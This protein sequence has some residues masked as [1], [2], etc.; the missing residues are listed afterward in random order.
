MSLI[1]WLVGLL[2]FISL[3]FTYHLRCVHMAKSRSHDLAFGGRLPE[4]GVGRTE[5][6]LL[7]VP[8]IPGRSPPGEGSPKGS[9]P[10]PEHL[11]VAGPERPAKGEGKA[12]L[13]QPRDCSIAQRILSE[14]LAG[15][16]LH[17]LFFSRAVH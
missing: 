2:I 7:C 16:G 13:V 12:E 4:A 17:R 1:C 3:S 10:A 5:L 15:R 6:K 14:L 11:R 9:V 8:G